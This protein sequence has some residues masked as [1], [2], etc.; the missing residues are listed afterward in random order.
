MQEFVVPK[1]I[2][3]TFDI[4]YLPFKEAE[5]QNDKML[6]PQKELAATMPTQPV[7]QSTPC[8]TGCIDGSYNYMVSHVI[9]ITRETHMGRH[10]TLKPEKTKTAPQ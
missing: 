9:S 6:F 2:P 1:S 4:G 7:R 3:K 8:V 5:P 10:G